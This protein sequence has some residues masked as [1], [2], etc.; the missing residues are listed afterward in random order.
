MKE[1]IEQFR[2][3]DDKGNEHKI[4]IYQDIIETRTHSG[5]Y[6]TPGLKEAI[7]S[8]GLRVNYLGDDTFEIAVTRQRLRKR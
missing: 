6:H 7:T 2:A 3:F 8:T 5:T 4:L 1:L